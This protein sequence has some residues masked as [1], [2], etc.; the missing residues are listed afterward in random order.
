MRTLPLKFATPQFQPFTES[1]L[2]IQI[3]FCISSPH[4]PKRQYVQWACVRCPLVHQPVKHVKVEVVGEVLGNPLSFRLFEPSKPSKAEFLVTAFRVEYVEWNLCRA[5]SLVNI[6]IPQ[7]PANLCQLTSS[8][9]APCCRFSFLIS[10]SSLYLQG[11][12]PA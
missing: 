3:Q 11:I 7:T 10:D 2:Y 5:P 8:M 1:S 6:R 4:G 12:L 9:S